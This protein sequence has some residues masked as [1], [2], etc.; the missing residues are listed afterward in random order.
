[1]K[2][3][4][5]SLICFA[6]LLVTTCAHAKGFSEPFEISSQ[7]ISYVYDGDTFAVKCRRCREG[8][9]KIR[10]LR[11]N[12]PELNAKNGSEARRAKKARQFVISKLNNANKIT[13]IPSKRRLYDKYGRLLASV[14]LDG[15]FLSDL[16]VSN[17]L[18]YRYENNGNFIKAKKRKVSIDKLI[19]SIRSLKSN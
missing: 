11:V 12:T 8:K 1:M 16:L 19:R 2:T 7:T 4:I 13:I 5:F 10:L 3:T 6:G 15:K 14:K 9:L 17:G 18:A